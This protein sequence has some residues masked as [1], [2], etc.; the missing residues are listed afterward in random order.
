M[1][2]IK[3]ILSGVLIIVLYFLISSF[4]T[5]PF[6][7][8]GINLEYVPA[9][10][11][12]IY[13]VSLQ[14]IMLAIFFFIIRVDLKKDITDFKKN[15]TTYL[16]KYSKYWFIGVIV[17]ISSNFLL[18]IFSGSSL[19]G[20]EEAVRKVL[21]SFPI[22]MFISSVFIAPFM[23]E[24]VFRKAFRNI[25]KR[26]WLFIILS[27]LVFGAM[28]LYNITSWVDF[29]YIIPYSSLGIAFAYMLAKTDNV[30]VPIMFHMMHNGILV[31][32]QI[33]LMIVN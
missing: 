32:L 26:D 28:H 7:L 10:F 16:T 22:Y 5:L 2:E 4:A 19:S 13:N 30:L 21:D 24:L 31:S 9:V 11:T 1:K 25:I 12:I 14:I 6:E 3:K 17:M 29:L 15:A 23:E 20:N 33:F 8:L 18:L 27:G